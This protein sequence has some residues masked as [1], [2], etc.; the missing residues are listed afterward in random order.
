MIAFVCANLIGISI[1]LCGFRLWKGPKLADR[2]VAID[3]I[4]ILILALVLLYANLSE[5]LVCLD[6][7]IV[8]AL[9][10]FLG[11]VIFAKFLQLA[12][13]AKGADKQKVTP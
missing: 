6:I 11:T 1:L 9:I 3:L 12:P 13:R 2:V 10:A 8:F 5:Q 7:A 4:G